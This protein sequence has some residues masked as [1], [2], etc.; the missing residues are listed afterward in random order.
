MPEKAFS[1]SRRNVYVKL[2][3]EERN[4]QDNVYLHKS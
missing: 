1:F 3:T 2:N 4:V